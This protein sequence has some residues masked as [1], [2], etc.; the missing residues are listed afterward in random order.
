M[1]ERYNFIK[2]WSDFIL[3][4]TLKTNDIDFVI[5]HSSSEL[6]LSHI[7]N[8]MIKDNNKILLTIY[9][10][11]FLHDIN[12]VFDYIN[13]LF[14]DR[15]GWFPSK[16][17]LYNL[18]DMKNE[19]IYDEEFLKNNK[20]KI[21]KVIITYEAKYDIEDILPDKLYHLSI[22]HFEKNII[23]NGL[24]PK[25]KNKQTITLDRIYVCKSAKDCYL[26]IN[27]MKN[28]YVYKIYTNN[29]N[30]INYKW[31][32]F[33]INTSDLNIKI[34]KDPNYIDNGYYVVDNIQPDNIKIYDK[35]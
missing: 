23:K 21:K 32:I 5:K 20:Q 18:S 27:K 9:D 26:L 16:Y 10:F 13:S 2:K 17:I 22:R 15:N 12:A 3:T 34:Y 29:L 25:S 11:N 28:E 19:L 7:K 30:T 4:E 14:I 35:E 1:I 24:F 31:V 33:E 8:D 6:N